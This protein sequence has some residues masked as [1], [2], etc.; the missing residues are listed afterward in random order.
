M[1][2]DCG[3]QSTGGGIQEGKNERGSRG[4]W[5]E[6]ENAQLRVDHDGTP[7]LR[8]GWEPKPSLCHRRAGSQVSLVV[9]K[10]SPDLSQ[11]PDQRRHRELLPSPFTAPPIGIHA[12]RVKY[13]AGLI[14]LGST[15]PRKRLHNRLDPSRQQ[16]ALRRVGPSPKQIFETRAQLEPGPQ[17]LNPRPSVFPELRTRCCNGRRPTASAIHYNSLMADAP[18]AFVLISLN[19]STRINL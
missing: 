15:Q 14:A 8:C 12:G 4:G 3:K 17:K 13:L 2:D 18:S 9:R 10:K 1:R 5:L 7:V 11:S 19:Q 6:A 16:I